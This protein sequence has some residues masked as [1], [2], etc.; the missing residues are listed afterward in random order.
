M[1]NRAGAEEADARDDLRGDACGI[2]VRAAVGREPDPRDVHRQ[3]R[4]QRRAD[5][6][7]N[8]RAQAGG[9]SGDLALDADRAAEQRGQEQLAEDAEPKRDDEIRRGLAERR[10]GDVGE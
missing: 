3:L 4:E 10:L 5:A 1:Q 2:A 7:E 6:D 9:F 8:V